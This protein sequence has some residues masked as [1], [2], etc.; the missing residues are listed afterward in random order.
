MTAKREGVGV[1]TGVLWCGGLVVCWMCAC[2]RMCHDVWGWRGSCPDVTSVFLRSKQF[3]PLTSCLELQ[4]FHR[5]EV[6]HFR[7]LLQR[8]QLPC[9]R[10]CPAVHLFAC[11]L[12]GHYACAGISM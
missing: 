11:R 9:H 12:T 10:A 7:L 6:K 1:D 5:G 8:T 2:A 4:H 3:P